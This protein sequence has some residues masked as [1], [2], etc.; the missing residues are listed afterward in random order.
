MS[1]SSGFQC[2]ESPSGWCWQRDHSYANSLNSCQTSCLIS[3]VDELGSKAPTKPQTHLHFALF[4]SFSSELIRLSLSLLQTQVALLTKFLWIG[5][6]CYESRNFAT[7]M[8]VLCG[9]E[10]VTVRQLPVRLLL[11]KPSS[12]LRWSQFSPGLQPVW[13]FWLRMHFHQCCSVRCRLCIQC[14]GM[15]VM[16][17]MRGSSW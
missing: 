2:S 13:L 17:S 6:H 16:S 4:S 1:Q 9:L 11:K 15:W 5:K 10:N 12:C 14:G 3:P 8:Q 7:A